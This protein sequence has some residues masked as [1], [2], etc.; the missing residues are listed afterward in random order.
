M[1]IHCVIAIADVCLKYFIKSD[2]EREREEDRVIYFVMLMEIAFGI[3]ITLLY[4]EIKRK[5][6]LRL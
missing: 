1:H 4:M 3:R 5:Y 6:V 2:G